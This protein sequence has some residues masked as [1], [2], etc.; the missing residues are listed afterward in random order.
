MGRRQVAV[1]DRQN[2]GQWV[3]AAAFAGGW[4][5]AGWPIGLGAAVL[6]YGVEC[7][8]FPWGGTCMKCFGRGRRRSW[9]SKGYRRCARC[10]GSGE[11]LRA[12][13]Q[14]LAWTRRQRER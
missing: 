11:A 4:L 9:F 8:L 1:E 10:G 12:G 6:L 5:F 3:L 13:R 2:L 7:W 14:L